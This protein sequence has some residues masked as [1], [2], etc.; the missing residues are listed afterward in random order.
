VNLRLGRGS[1]TELVEICAAGLLIFSFFL[2][3]FQ[4]RAAD[5]V[6]SASWVDLLGRSNW[7]RALEAQLVTFGAVV[8]LLAAVAVT[9]EVRRE[10][11]QGLAVAGFGASIFGALWLLFESGN[12]AFF[13][14][15]WGAGIDRGLGLLLFAGA[16][17]VG[18]IVAIAGFFL[19]MH[20]APAVDQTP[21]T[22]VA[23]QPAPVARLKAVHAAAAAGAAATA[24]AA[25][26]AGAGASTHGAGLITIVELG[27][28]SSLNVAEGER[29]IVGRDLGSDI[30]VSD[31]KVSRRQAMIEW[32]NGGWVIRDISTTNPTRLLDS[33]GG[34][35]VLADQMRIASGQLLMGDV[36]ITLFPT[37]A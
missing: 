13:W 32:T 25:A 31:A 24:E 28:S 23:P 27:R 10:L 18:A 16:A 1:R 5:A 2:P 34:V 8:A 30:R 26:S 17:A 6:G 36:L 19:P 14:G 3:W 11:A 7:M 9:L 12:A 22:P 33:S 21:P 15:S 35:H 29:V 37:G 4:G 20:A